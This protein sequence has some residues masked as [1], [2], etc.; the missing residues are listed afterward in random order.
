MLFS[1]FIAA[2][3][4][5]PKRTFVSI[6]TVISILGVVLAVWMLTVVIAVFT[7]YGESLKESILGFEPHM[8]VD[9]DGFVSDYVPI[10][11]AMQK[12]DGISG[13]APFVSGQ[14]IMDYRG[15]RSTLTIRGILPPEGEE[16]E[17]LESKI[18]KQ[19]DLSAPPGS[20]QTIRRGDFTL[21]DFYSAVIGDALADAQGIEIG[22][23]LLLYSPP[24]PQTL[25][26]RFEQFT[27]SDSNEVRD[28]IVDDIKVFTSPQEVTVTGIFDSGHWDFDSTIIYLHLET[29]QVLYGF[30][31]EKC[32]G[33]AARVEDAYRAHDYQEKLYEFLPQ[34]FRAMT[35]GERYRGIFNA[36]ATEKQAMYIILF[37]IMVVSAFCIMNTMITVTVQKRSE[38][39][40][41]KALGSTEEQIIRIFLLQGLLVGIIGV[42]VGM[43][44]AQWTIFE[45]N[46]IG[47]WLGDTFGIAIFAEDIYK[48]DGGIPA[49]QSLK[50]LITISVGS[51][52]A[53]TLA[54][55]IPALIAAS[56]QPAKAL[57]S[58]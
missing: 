6:I 13:I 50:D 53:C 17:R 3:Y 30:D 24:D 42:V 29:A 8:T 31:L 11:E 12:V 48:V 44:L 37:M 9:S 46:A 33:V 10:V 52:L 28:E 16:L 25:M 47:A 49:K 34:Q 55:L 5:K 15:R 45:R 43:A 56:L 38:I 58:E 54:A 18:A 36:V 4:L 20:N 41:L 27:N 39:G 19:T 2:R 40:L 1:P 51:F 26:D 7:G 32:H 35:W 22:H 21:P 23:T 14:V 57:R